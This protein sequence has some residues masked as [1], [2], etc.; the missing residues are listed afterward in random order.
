MSKKIQLSTFIVDCIDQY[1][2]LFPEDW[3]EQLKWDSDENAEVSFTKGRQK[4]LD[5]VDFCFVRIGNSLLSGEY[6][7]KRKYFDT[8]KDSFEKYWKKEHLCPD[9]GNNNALREDLYSLYEELDNHIKALFYAYTKLVVAVDE[10][11]ESDRQNYLFKIDTFEP[12]PTRYFML[13]VILRDIIIPICDIE[14]HLAYEDDIRKKLVFYIEHLEYL[15][16]D[17]EESDIKRVLILTKYKASFILKK[18]ISSNKPFNILIDCEKKTLSRESLSY[19]PGSINKLFYQY[20][21]VHE[22]CKYSDDDIINCQHHIIS[23]QQSFLDMALLMH[24]YCSTN[25]TIQQI[26]NLLNQFK[27]KYNELFR[28]KYHFTFDNHA[29]CTL[30]NFMYNCRLSYKVNLKYPLEEI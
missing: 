24:Y 30:L 5:F 3:I 12:T 6:I 28:K 23:E 13:F 4:I 18:L 1:K 21:C 29:L 10:K 8:A 16:N 17:K 27:L 14:H 20:E 26:D 25:K 15:C 22:K 2:I 9:N 7:V 11:L 19:L